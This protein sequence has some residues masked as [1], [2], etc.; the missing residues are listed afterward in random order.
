[1]FATEEEIKDANFM[2]IWS[3]YHILTPYFILKSKSFCAFASA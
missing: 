2:M 1:L 3:I